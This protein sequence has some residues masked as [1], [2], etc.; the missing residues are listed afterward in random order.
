[1]TRTARSGLVIAAIGR[2]RPGDRH[3]ATRTQRRSIVFAQRRRLRSACAI[4]R[5]CGCRDRRH[6]G[7]ACSVAA[8]P[9]QRSAT[10]SVD[11]VEP[12]S[13]ANAGSRTSARSNGSVVW[14]PLTTTSS[15]ARRIRRIAASR[16]RSDRHDLGDHRVVVGRDALARTDG[17]VDPDARAGRHRPTRR[18]GPATGANSRAGSSAAKRTSIGMAGRASAAI[19]AAARTA[20]DSGSPAAIHS[21]SATRSRSV[22]SSVT[23]CSTWSRALTSRNQK[24]RSGSKRNSAVAALWSPA[25][26][27]RPDRHRRAARLARRLSGPGAGDSSTS[28][29]CRRWIEQSRSPSATT[30]PAVVTEQLDLDVARRSDLALEVDR[31]ITECRERLGRAGGQRGRQARSAS[32][33]VACLVRRR[34]PPP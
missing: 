34:R 8:A 18:R 1:M 13:S 5:A 25:A 28:F 16:S 4:G 20:S 26:R 14:M 21:C 33:R 9:S 12:V 11:S 17:R 30:S 2:S 32:R 29:W 6:R 3:V 22:T 19:A 27:R 15:R 10:Q 24:R 7:D 31:S 23:P